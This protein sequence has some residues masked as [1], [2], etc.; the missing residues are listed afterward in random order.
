MVKEDGTIVL[1]KGLKKYV[2]V[3]NIYVDPVLKSI[4]RHVKNKVHARSYEEKDA[5]AKRL[6]EVEYEKRV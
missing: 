3:S 2:E 4:L 1:H 6:M 5:I